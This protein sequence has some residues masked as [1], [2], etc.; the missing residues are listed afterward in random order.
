MTRFLQ[1]YAG[2]WR[3]FRISTEGEEEKMEF[4]VGL[5][6][7]WPEAALQGRSAPHFVFYHRS[8]FMDETE[9]VRVSGEIIAVSGALFMIGARS[10]DGTLRS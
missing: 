1:Q 7:I 3:V 5:L 4:S 6:S 2:L 9:Y 10:G 8:K